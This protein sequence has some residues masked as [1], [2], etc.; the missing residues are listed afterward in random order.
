MQLSEE[1]PH[2]ENQEDDKLL[3]TT[4]MNDLN[5]TLDNLNN[6]NFTIHNSTVE[7]DSFSKIK[8]S[9]RRK[10]L[11]SNSSVVSNESNP[12]DKKNSSKCRKRN[13]FHVKT[14]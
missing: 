10:R 13:I 12:D 14:Q 6:C 2:L 11:C 3:I 7:S 5:N 8:M 1:K 9:I 4:N